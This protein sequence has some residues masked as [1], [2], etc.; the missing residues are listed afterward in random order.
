M[1]RDRRRSG[2]WPR[3]PGAG[4]RIETVTRRIGPGPGPPDPESDPTRQP[5]GPAGPAGL[6]TG[7]RR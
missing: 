1:T 6:G 2:G 7:V 5:G 4:R 3:S